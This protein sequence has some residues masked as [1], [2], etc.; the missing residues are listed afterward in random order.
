MTYHEAIRRLFDGDPR[1]RSSSAITAELAALWPSEHWKRSTVSTVLIALC[2][3]HSSRHHYPTYARHAFLKRDGRGRYRPWDDERDGARQRWLAPELV[4]SPRDRRSPRRGTAPTRTDA[5]RATLRAPPWRVTDDRIA[6]PQP[7]GERSQ[8]G[9]HELVRSLVERIHAQPFQPRYRLRP[10]GRHVIGWPARLRSYFWPTPSMDLDA[11]SR[12]MTPWFERAGELARR[13]DDGSAWTLEH[14]D[15]A[16]ELALTMLRWGRVPPRTPVSPAVVEAV[17]QRALGRRVTPTPPMNSGWTKVAALATAF[18]EEHPERNPH[19]IWDSRVS[20]SLIAHLDSVMI[21]AGARD[22][23]PLFPGIGTV[24]GRGG[25]RKAS[26]VT[27]RLEL[28]WPNGYGR[29]RTQDAGSLLVREIRDVLN[30][31][32]FPAM[33]L[34]LGGEG[35]WTVRGVESALFMDGY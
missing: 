1:E 12:A 23:S 19:V 14:R 21:E 13:L 4:A 27:A 20:T 30:R 3:D 11:T 7:D 32:G 5:S 28:R 31:C 10:L 34:P 15:E 35:A 16:T 9:R 18:L 2:V 25:T 24:A 17:F 22:P 6:P 29:W 33:P 8:R 26:P